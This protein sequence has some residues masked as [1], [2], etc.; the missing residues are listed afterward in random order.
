MNENG[1]CVDNVTSNSMNLINM[2][3]IATSVELVASQKLFIQLLKCKH[4]IN[5]PECIR[6]G[7]I[8]F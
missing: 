6:N 1:K 8:E 7:C 4:A 5:T 3:C 2:L